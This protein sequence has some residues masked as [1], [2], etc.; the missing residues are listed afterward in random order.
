MAKSTLFILLSNDDG[1]SSPGIQV[2]AK[3]LRRIAKVV[4]VAPD[5]EQSAT[6]HSLTLH[7]PLRVT[8]H[9]PENYSV[10]GTPTDCI[11]LAIHEILKSKPDLVVSGI[12][13]GA[14]LGDD[15]HYSGTVSAAMEGAI[16]GI[17][18]VAVSLVV[19]GDD[20]PHFKTA[21]QFMLRLCCR[22]LNPD[23]PALLSGRGVLNVNVPNLPPS[24]IRGHCFTRLGKRNYGEV[25]FEKIDPRGKKYYWIGGDE[26]TFATIRGSDAEAILA[27]KIS[28]TPL[29]VDMTH[30][31]L[32]TDL[33][34]FKI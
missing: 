12:N 11:T 10:D 22:L 7:R 30:H 16:M 19:W 4:V 17:R 8:R 13:R 3:T 23:K 20:V 24:S 26:R 27:K 15:V 25:I 14:N 21:G 18:A 28:M 34:D 33:K 1:F 5:R 6:S 9:S 32:L 31:S 29:Q 2:L